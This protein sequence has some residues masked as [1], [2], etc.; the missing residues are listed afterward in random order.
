M[1]PPGDVIN[2]KF[3]QKGPQLL[4]HLPMLIER[5]KSEVKGPWRWIVRL[6]NSSLKI[7][8]VLSQ[9]GDVINPKL[10]RKR[11][12]TC[13]LCTNGDRKM[14]IKSKR[15][16]EVRYTFMKLFSQNLEFLAPYCHVIISKLGQK[17]SNLH[18]MYNWW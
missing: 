9:R 13:I 5:W 6:R 1:P 14:K 7:F 10:A 8:E 11:T 15:N 18:I 16:F 17:H 4:F 3:C 2:P 12:E